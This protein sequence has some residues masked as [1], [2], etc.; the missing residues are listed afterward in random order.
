MSIWSTAKKDLIIT[1]GENV[2]SSEVENA[3]Y[4]LAGVHE[5]AVIGTP[6]E[7]LGEMVTAV[8][9]PAPGT[10]LDVDTVIAHCRALIG[11]YKIPAPRRVR[12]RHAEKRHGQD[13]EE[14]PA[15]QLQRLSP[16]RCRGGFPQAFPT[17][18]RQR[19]AR[20]G[21]RL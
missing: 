16:A 9:V 11:G 3:L 10:A 6:D 19:I 21:A 20:A 4:Q 14:Q 13:P 2:Y 15:R 5:C 17:A 12:R 8:I 18:G 7:R 1:G